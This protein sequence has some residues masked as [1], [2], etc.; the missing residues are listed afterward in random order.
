MPKVI[1]LVAEAVF[2][3]QLL[4]SRM[5]FIF[6]LPRC[7]GSPL[8]KC[9]DVHT[10][11]E[12]GGKTAFPCLLPGSQAASGRLIPSCFT[13]PTVPP[14]WD[15]GKPTRVKGL[16]GRLILAAAQLTCAN[17][18]TGTGKALEG[19]EKHQTLGL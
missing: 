14:A 3:T 12:K 8:Y 11:V 1:Q 19:V 2:I 9:R 18:A 6:T 4:D 7:P 5:H 15:P 13:R 10:K 17:T 16:P